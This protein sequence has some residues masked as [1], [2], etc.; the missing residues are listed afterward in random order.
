MPNDVWTHI[1]LVRASASTKFYINGKSASSSW[2]DTVD[3]STN[4]PFKIASNNNTGAYG[5]NGYISDVRV[6][7]GTAIYTSN[8]TPTSAP[9]SAVT[10][11]SLLVKGT[12]ASIIDK[13]Q[14][15]NL[16]LEGN[17]TDSTTTKFT[18]A[19]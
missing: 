19:K 4:V 7:K 1:S 16:K 15:A 9:L 13:S 2:G 17:A 10:N 3:Y 5:Y 18:S 6:V 8:F 14:G 12:D 11:T